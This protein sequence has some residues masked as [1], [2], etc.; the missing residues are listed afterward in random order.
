MRHEGDELTASGKM[1]EVGDGDQRLA[2]I[3][4]E[5]R[6]L[7]MR[8]LQKRFEHAE[9]V[10]HGERRRMNRISAKVAQKVG[11]LLEEHGRNAGAREEQCCHHSRR[12][13]ADDAAAGAKLA[14][15]SDCV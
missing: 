5:R 6:H 8:A 4:G 14:H 9:F 7:L 13:A 15:R 11:V 10:H 2:E 1:R 12:S 3:A